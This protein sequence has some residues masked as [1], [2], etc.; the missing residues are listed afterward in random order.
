MNRSDKSGSD[1]P[2]VRADAWRRL[3]V[4]ADQMPKYAAERNRVVPGHTNVS[5]LS[6][7][8]RHR[9]LSEQ[10]FAAFAIERH[11]F[12]EVEKLVQ[13][14][15]WRLYWKSWLEMRP[16]IWT[17]Y[18]SD[19]DQFSS[20]AWRAGEKVMNGQSGID[21]IDYFARELTTTGYL[22]NHA[23]MWF[24][25]AWIHHFGLPW[26]MGADFFHQHLLDGDPASNTLSWR[27]VAGLHTQGKSY[28][29]RPAN[30]EKYVDLEILDAN[31][32][33]LERLDGSIANIP[34]EDP[35]P[36]RSLP[37]IEDGEAG[38]DC[39][40]IGWWLHDDDLQL[41]E[42]WKGARAVAL[43]SRDIHVQARY[44]ENRKMFIQ[45]GLRD[46]AKQM[47]S[48]AA[49][50]FAETSATATFLGDWADDHGLKTIVAYQPWVGPIRDALP[51]I[52]SQL[53]RRGIA[54]QLH[55][56]PSDHWWVGEAT[57]GF[58]GFWKKVCRNQ[59]FVS[60]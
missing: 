59:A 52:E 15:Y 57:A 55:R 9:V 41:G 21:I 49:V 42:D 37:K 38:H 2:A 14:I 12:R 29:A 8:I 60:E 35:I 22:H 48:R 53:C 58:F 16:D 30:I 46:A 44:G 4:F 50:E 43:L 23:R 51:E 39:E 28:L 31:R 47:E 56:K 40:Q 33:G 19:R 7:A 3:E 11:G 13:E 5:Q 18:C 45:Q 6:P 34:S 17:R 27:W 54:L 32:A 10:E 24:A 26:E 1:F 36:E 20:G 25:G